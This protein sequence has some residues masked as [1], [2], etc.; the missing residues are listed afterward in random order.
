MTG[1][2]LKTIRNVLLMS[3]SSVA[4]MCGGQSG[5]TVAQQLFT[6]TDIA[7]VEAGTTNTATNPILN[8]LL[9]NLFR[10]SLNYVPVP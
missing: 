3:Q 7:T 8:T 2:E 6:A 10:K 9:E 5:A 4:A 1:N